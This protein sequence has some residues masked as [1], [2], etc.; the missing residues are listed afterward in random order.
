[1]R[2]IV[3]DA[4]LPQVV[5]ASVGEAH[6]IQPFHRD[7]AFVRIRH[8]KSATIDDMMSNEEFIR[9]LSIVALRRNSKWIMLRVASGTCTRGLWHRILLCGNFW[10]IRFRMAIVCLRFGVA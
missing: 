8:I 4:G 9:E 1:M 6:D 5:D 7:G 3:I 2:P 10:L